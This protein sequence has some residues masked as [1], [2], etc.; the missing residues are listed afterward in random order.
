MRRRHH[1]ESG[2]VKVHQPSLRTRSAGSSSAS[3]CKPSKANM[4]PIFGRPSPRVSPSRSAALHQG[5]SLKRRC[6]GLA[7]AG[8]LME[9]PCNRQRAAAALAVSFPRRGQQ[10]GRKQNHGFGQSCAQTPPDG[11]SSL[12]NGNGVQVGAANTCSPMPARARRGPIHMPAVA[13]RH[14]I[15][16]P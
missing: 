5:Y 9:P 15:N 8:H 12:R 11:L 14:W 4:T 3:Q 7:V 13:G 6:F 1:A 10:F 2:F 16:A